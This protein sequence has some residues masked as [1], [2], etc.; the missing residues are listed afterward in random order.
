MGF[1]LTNNNPRTLRILIHSLPRHPVIVGEWCMSTGTVMQVGQ[2]FVNAAVRSFDRTSGWFLWNWK[3]ERGI[4]FD[5]WDVQYQHA[6][7]GMDALAVYDK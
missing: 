5:S 7:R 3:V 1:A 6:I 2:P 4:G